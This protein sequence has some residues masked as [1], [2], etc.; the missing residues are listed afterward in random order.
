MLVKPTVNLG[1]LP[2]VLQIA[3]CA[4]RLGV[5]WVF[6][7]LHAREGALVFEKILTTVGKRWL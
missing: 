4:D 3:R 6:V 5:S 2:V 7:I 1:A